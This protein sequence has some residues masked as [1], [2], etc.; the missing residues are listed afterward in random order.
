MKRFL[1]MAEGNKLHTVDAPNAK[2]AYRNISGWYNPTT[3]IIIIDPNT[4]YTHIFSRELDKN[5]N[6]ISIFDLLED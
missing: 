6:L 2:M 4:K 5:G 3:K 1:Y